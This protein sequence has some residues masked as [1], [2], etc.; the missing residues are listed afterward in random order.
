MDDDAE[1]QMYLQGVMKPTTD[2]DWV[3]RNYGALKATYL[4]TGAVKLPQVEQAAP[5]FD[6]YAELD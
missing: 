3:R 2:R 4:R 1:F 6:R 5:R